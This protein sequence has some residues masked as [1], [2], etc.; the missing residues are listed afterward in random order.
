MLGYSTMMRTFYNGSQQRRM[1]RSMFYKSDW[2]S[3]RAA[4]RL[5]CHDND[6][7]GARTKGKRCVGTALIM[8]EDIT[9]S[10]FEIAS[11]IIGRGVV[12]ECHRRL[13]PNSTKVETVARVEVGHSE[14]WRGQ[15]GMRRFGTSSPWE[16]MA[17][18]I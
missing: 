6:G 10:W 8:A 16:R 9:I 14:H 11:C 4:C 2:G 7:G 13:P 17:R 3:G 15:M 1:H 12:V 5:N 18:C